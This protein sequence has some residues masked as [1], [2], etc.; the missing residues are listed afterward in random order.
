MRWVRRFF[1]EAWPQPTDAAGVRYLWIYGPWAIAL[2][3]SALIAEKGNMPYILVGWGVAA[4]I[5][6]TAVFKTQRWR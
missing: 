2:G 3:L 1:V 5:S 4:L 6:L